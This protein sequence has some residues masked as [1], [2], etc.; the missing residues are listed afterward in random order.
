MSPQ[1]LMETITLHNKISTI[2][3]EADPRR[4][5]P[6]PNA[7]RTIPQS[8]HLSGRKEPES[9]SSWMHRLAR[10][11][12]HAHMRHAFPWLGTQMKLMFPNAD[13]KGIFHNW[14]QHLATA[15]GLEVA[16]TEPLFI[17]D[18]GVRSD[19]RTGHVATK[20]LLSNPDHV[21]G[22]RPAWHA[23]CPQCIEG[24]QAAFWLKAWRLPTSIVCEEHH[25]RLLD[26]CTRCNHRFSIGT[27]IEGSL[28]S[29]NR[30]GMEIAIMQADQADETDM[31][32]SSDF[33]AW[34]ADAA[35]PVKPGSQADRH[36]PLRRLLELFEH[37]AL[38][39]HLLRM[40]DALKSDFAAVLARHH[41]AW[42]PG[43]DPVP[44]SSWCLA[45]R[46]A[47]MRNVVFVLQ[48]H[49]IKEFMQELTAAGG[50]TRWSFHQ[51]SG[52][53]LGQLN[54]VIAGGLPQPTR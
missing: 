41:Q 11:N 16:H 28:G 27:E 34:L 37:P 33:H 14:P 44:F 51:A 3:F 25:V 32:V 5:N 35:A 12:G 43:K 30:C 10:D 42:R 19:E 46:A 18:H 15:A 1:S 8:V 7:I 29:C 49:P 50:W 2:R 54:A 53:H 20:L 52:C 26:R 24:M 22:P 13:F 23:V 9:L 45:D 47:G 48:L 17:S 38:A 4:L 31:R 36:G 21:D 39:M 40:W 6:S